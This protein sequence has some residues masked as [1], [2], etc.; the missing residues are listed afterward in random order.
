[1]PGN[2]ILGFHW[3][4]SRLT[5][6]LELHFG[7]NRR[8][9]SF[10]QGALCFKCPWSV[11]T[12]PVHDVEIGRVIYAVL[13]RSMLRLDASDLRGAER[14]DISHTEELEGILSKCYGSE[15]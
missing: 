9:G 4:K 2:V 3:L 6:R 15:L 1:V 12:L 7:S 10:V 8:A 11:Q 14:P 5:A 13:S